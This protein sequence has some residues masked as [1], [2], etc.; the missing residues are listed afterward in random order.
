MSLYQSI[1]SIDFT[2]SL[3]SAPWNEK[4]DAIRRVGVGSCDESSKGKDILR[5]EGQRMTGGE[6]TMNIKLGLCSA[7][8]GEKTRLRCRRMIT[9]VRLSSRRVIQ[10]RQCVKPSD[11]RWSI[12]QVIS[13]C[14][15]LKK[16]QRE[17]RSECRESV[18]VQVVSTSVSNCCLNM[19]SLVSMDRVVQQMERFLSS[20]R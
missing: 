8:G 6:I 18:T 5:T 7:V 4:M 17:T 14:R 20:R 19:V 3:A 10:S 13:F 1:N 15:S 2:L 12:R 11:K 16:Q 9:A